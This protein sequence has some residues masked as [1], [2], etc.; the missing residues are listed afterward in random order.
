MPVSLGG[1]IDGVDFSAAQARYERDLAERLDTSVPGEVTLTLL[2]EKPSARIARQYVRQTWPD[3]D[4]DTTTDVELIVSELVTNA[5]RHG[6]PEINLRLRRDPFAVDIAV[7]DHGEQMPP[8]SV[9]QA[10]VT[11]EHGRGLFLIDNLAS[12]WGV[13]PLD[14]EPGKA[15]WASVSSA[16]S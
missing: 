4:D 7:L 10:D 13:S 1:H 15:V 8:S 11:A 9:T 6:A 12:K 14:G 3:L 2:A 5:V 16:R